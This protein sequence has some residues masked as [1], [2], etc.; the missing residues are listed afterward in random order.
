MKSAAS[1]QDTCQRDIRLSTRFR[2]LA[3]YTT[4]FSPYQCHF[5]LHIEVLAG[6]MQTSVW[7]A[8]ENNLQHSQFLNC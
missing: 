3:K 8:A 6:S 1:G 7:Q 5:G 4:I 2:A